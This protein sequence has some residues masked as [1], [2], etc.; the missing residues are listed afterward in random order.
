MPMTAE[1]ANVVKFV[2]YATAEPFTN[3]V[4]KRVTPRVFFTVIII[5]WG[6]CMTLMGLVTSYGGLLAAR[7]ALGLAEAGLYPGKILALFTT[8]RLSH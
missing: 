8:D 1:S 7:F 3:V 2:S 6:V 4:L 5:L